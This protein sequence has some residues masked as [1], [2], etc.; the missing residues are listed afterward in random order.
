MQTLLIFGFNEWLIYI[1]EI[2]YFSGLLSNCPT[3]ICQTNLSDLIWVGM[4]GGYKMVYI[5]I[6]F[7]WLFGLS[8]TKRIGYLPYL[9]WGGWWLHTDRILKFRVIQC[10]YP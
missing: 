3:N 4:G 6:T 2:A 8:I 5:F 10:N 7:S 9:S 1:I